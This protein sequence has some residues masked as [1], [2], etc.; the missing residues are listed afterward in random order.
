[1]DRGCEVKRVQPPVR[2]R[3]VNKS[4]DKEQVHAQ[5]A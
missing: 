5:R 1:M 2:R 4:L 3:I